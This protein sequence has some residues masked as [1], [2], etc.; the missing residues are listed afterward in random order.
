MDQQRL[1][2]SQEVN[3]VKMTDLNSMKVIIGCE[4][5][6]KYREVKLRAAYIHSQAIVNQY[7]TMPIRSKLCQG[8]SL[9]RFVRCI[10]A[11]NHVHSLHL[12]YSVHIVGQSTALYCTNT[13][14]GTEYKQMLPAEK[15][16]IRANTHHARNCIQKGKK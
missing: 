12:R 9:Q 3:S 16:S 1:P 5:M 2:K 10:S 7:F 15:R 11:D 14:N 8:L 13:N 6:R 4:A